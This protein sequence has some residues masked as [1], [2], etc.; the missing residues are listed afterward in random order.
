MS[1]NPEPDTGAGLGQ[2]DDDHHGGGEHADGDL[3]H[4]GDGQRRRHPAEHDR[5][6]DGDI[7]RRGCGGGNGIVVYSTSGSAQTNRF[8]S[9]GRFFKQ[10]DIPHFAQAVVGG[11]A[12][13]TQC[14][15]KN[16][17]ADGSL[18]FAIVSFIVPS[19]AT[20]GTQVS[21]QDQGTGNNTGY[22][23]QSEC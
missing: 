5:Q 17:W 19:V 6:P 8:V 16:R 2:L 12:I 14:D 1:F 11:T 21:F 15:V 23:A 10:G 22:L 20:G 3:S 18:K 13:L 9:I 4:H 7:F